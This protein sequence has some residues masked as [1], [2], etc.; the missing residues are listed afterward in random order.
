MNDTPDLQA[1]TQTLQQTWSKGDFAMVAS[2][3]FHAADD[4]AEELQIFPGERVL[5]VA[6]GSGNGAISAARRAWGNTTGLDFVPELLERGRER[7]AAERLE[8]DFVEGD[9]QSLPFGDGEFDVT[10]SIFGAMFAPDQQKTA[11]ELLRV[12]KAGGRIGMANWC[13]DGGLERLFLT[14]M[15]HTGGPPPGVM[16]PVLWGNEDHLKQLFGDGVTDLRT[17]RLKSRQPFFSADHYIDFFRSYFGPIKSAFE[18]VGPEGEQALTDD[19]REMLTDV[20]T[21]GEKAL[22]IEPEYLRVVA[23]RA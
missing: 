17:E 2:I 11:N 20:N 22:V 9:A 18:Q 23:T 14:V 7:A 3:V 8:I 5:D 6:C 1:V 16:P 19:L 21:A 4:L 10:M 15:K 12:T 13:P